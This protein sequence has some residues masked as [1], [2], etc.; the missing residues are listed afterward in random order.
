LASGRIFE[1]WSKLPWIN[2]GA[3]VEVSLIGFSGKDGEDDARLDG[4]SV[5]EIYSDLTAVSSTVADLTCAEPLAENNGAA[6]QGPTKGGAFDITGDQARAWLAASG[7]PN[8]RG[9][10]DVVG[11]SSRNGKYRTLG[12]ETGSRKRWF[13]RID[14]EKPHRSSTG[15]QGRVLKNHSRIENSFN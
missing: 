12:R 8:G 7:N 6:L 4:E 3:A 11:V 10:R 13:S 1:A 14:L 9:N 15:L 5:V 2:D